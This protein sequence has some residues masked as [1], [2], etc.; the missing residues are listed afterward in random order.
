MSV[1][2][3][4]PNVTLV[5]DSLEDRGHQSLYEQRQRGPCRI[6]ETDPDPQQ[7]AGAA[8]LEDLLIS[9]HIPLRPLMT[10]TVPAHLLAL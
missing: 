2:L 9:T 10:V 4:L 8:I 3:C 7:R 1:H 6:M 5:L